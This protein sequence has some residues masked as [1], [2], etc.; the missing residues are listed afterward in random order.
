MIE[1]DHPIPSLPVW[2]LTRDN[3]NQV[4]SSV[5]LGTGK[6]ILFGVPGAFTPTCSTYHL[7]GFV[8]HYDDFKSLGVE[9][10]VCASVNDHFVMRAWA[11][12]HDALGKIEFLAD[13]DAKLVMDLGLERDLTAG[14]LG[15]R[16]IRS[17]LVVDKGI[18]QAVFIDDKPGAL[19][20]T[21]A[22]NILAYL[23]Q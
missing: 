21:G 5:F 20:N 19:T 3:V 16:Y 10:I 9:K 11:L 22:A 8:E 23:R 2:V 12:E 4:D 14:G 15:I 13:F 18:V 17:A 7:P 1:P 6:T